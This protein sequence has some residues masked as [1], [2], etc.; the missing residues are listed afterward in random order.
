MDEERE[1]LL[2]SSQNQPKQ[3]TYVAISHTSDVSVDGGSEELYPKSNEHDLRRSVSMGDII[4]PIS[5]SWKNV[6]VFVEINKNKWC[7]RKKSGGIE[8]KQLLRNVNGLVKPGTLL[9]IIGASGAGK[10]TL[11]NVLTGR[12]TSQYTIRGDIQVNGITVG[13]GIKNISAYVQQDELFIANLTVKETLVFRALLRMDKCLNKQARLARVDEVIKEMGLQKCEN[14]KVG[15]PSGRKGISGGEM[16]RLSFACEMLTNPPL[17]FCD[18]PTSG[19]DSFMAQNIVQTLKETTQKGRTILCTIHQP[20]SEVFALF[21]HVLLLAEGRTAF[22]GTAKNAFAFFNG[23]NYPCPVNFNPADFYV[24]TLAI[25]PGNESECRETVEKI[26]DA[27]DQ[28]AEMT[29]I[30]HDTATLSEQSSNLTHSVL[31]EDAF[32]EQHN[33]YKTSWIKQF[34]TVIWRSWISLV[35]DDLLFKVRGGQTLVLSVILGLV[36]L[37]QDYDMIGVRNI[38]GALFLMITNQSFT[39]LFAVLNTFPIEIAVFLREYGSGLYR[40]DVYYIAKV[41]AEFPSFTIFPILFSCII[42]WM[43]G[44]YNSVTAFLMYT[45]VLI[46]V[47]NTAGGFGY[48]VSSLARSVNVALSVAPPIMIPFMLFGGFFVTDDSIPVYFI[49]L[50]FVSWFKYANELLII[51]QW[52][53][54]THIDCHKNATSGKGCFQNGTGVI[55]DMQYSKDNLYFDVGMMFT[56]LAVFHIFTFIFVLI[57]A[58]RSKS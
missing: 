33:R 38:N 28:S 11:M 26:C 1:L 55:E 42:Y 46:L 18:E 2:G 7:R 35:R 12:N 20:S 37:Q 54:V 52:E 10:S 45:G 30:A 24:L 15:S 8:S 43:V 57:R 3:T 58:R 48:L 19:L 49:W 4:E 27:F 13:R 5:L 31:F 34:R 25:V 41:L 16:K 50:K 29:S 9:A 32:D 51:I 22:M 39:S 6:N 40:V 21:D 44:L 14:T 53:D 56:L 23:L 17:M 47:A 36:Y